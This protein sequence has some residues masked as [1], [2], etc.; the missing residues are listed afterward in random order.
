MIKT[1]TDNSLTIRFSV[2]GHAFEIDLLSI[3]TV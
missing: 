2:F 3:K 1:V